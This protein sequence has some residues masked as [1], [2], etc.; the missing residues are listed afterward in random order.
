[1][2]SQIKFLAPFLTN[3]HKFR[4][5]RFYVRG[6]FLLLFRTVTAKK[7]ILYRL[8]KRNGHVILGTKRRPD[9]QAVC[10]IY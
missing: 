5:V 7:Y 9:K 10:I 2:N 4:F 3:R 6:I 8:I 1:M